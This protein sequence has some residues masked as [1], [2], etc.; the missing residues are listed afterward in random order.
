MLSPPFAMVSPIT[1][2]SP[3][4]T[5]WRPCFP[6]PQARIATMSLRTPSPR[7][8]RPS[9]QI[10]FSGTRV[11]PSAAATEMPVRTLTPAYWPAQI[12]HFFGR[13]P[14]RDDAFNTASTTRSSRLVPANNPAAA[15]IVARL[16]FIGSETP[17]GGSVQALIRP[18][19]LFSELSAQADLIGGR[20]RAN[21]AARDHRLTDAAWTSTGPQWT[22][23]G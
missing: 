10:Q 4:T 23:R 16:A 15:A 21:V 13:P 3:L 17:T 5:A 19:P 20:S 18:G 6:E 22:T 8:T 7:G 11:R 1:P 14:A 2:A 9:V 12:C